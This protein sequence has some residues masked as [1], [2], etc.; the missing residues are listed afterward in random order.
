MRRPAARRAWISSLLL[1]PLAA[2]AAEGKRAANLFEDS[3]FEM[4]AG[5]WR[6]DKGKGTT[7]SFKVD[8]EAAFEG[9]RSML[10]TI[11]A[12]GDYG[13][14]FGQIV[15]GGQVGKTYTFA[16]FVRSEGGPTQVQL[17]IERPAKPWDRAVRSE[18]FT[19]AKDKWAELHVTFKVEKPFAE[20]WF[21]YVSCNRPNV[22]F[23]VD[24]F[25]LYEGD[26]V[27]FD[28]AAK[29][30]A[31]VSGVSLYEMLPTHSAPF[32]LRWSKKSGLRKIPEG[33]TP[34]PF[35]ALSSA[36][37]AN[38]RLA[39]EVHP[40]GAVQLYSVGEK[41]ALPRASLRP[42]P[43]RGASCTLSIAKNG[44]AASA[45]DV[46]YKD[47]AGKP[48][49]LRVELRMGQA[50]VETEPRGA[51][52]G[53]S[54][55]APCRFAILPDFFADDI[56][57]DAAELPVAK[58]ELPSE[59][60][61]IH[62]LPD[63]QALVMAV[64]DV[65]GDDVEVTLVGEGKER[66]IASS[67]IRFGSKGKIW[68]A[69][70]AAPGIWHQH[71]VAKDDAGKIV[72]LDWKP[73]FGAQWR[74]DW[75][76]EDGLSDSWEMIAQRSDGNF[77]KHWLGS[78]GTV[79]ANRKRWTT[80][81]GSFLYPCWID[82][83]GDAFLQPFA[84]SSRWLGPAVMYPLGRTG[85]TPLDTFTVLD[86]VR[87]TL[88]VGPCEYILDLEGQQ[89][90]YKGTATCANRDFLNPIY[91]RG[92]Q[93]KRRADINR[94]LDEVMLFIRH[95]RGRIE[96]YRDFGHEL[97]KYLAQHKQAH[98]ELAE[99]IAELETLTKAIDAYVDKRRGEIKT[100]DEAQAMVDDF[101]RTM[102]D[103][104][105]KDAF[106]RCKKFTSAIVVIGGSQDEL[107]GET[108]MA[109]KWVRQRAGLLM[110]LEPRIAPIAREIRART[111]K[112]LRS[113][114]G[115]EGARH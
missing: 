79:P 9:Q 100:P 40:T 58:A 53:L 42:V 36:V 93:K 19:I 77:V 37:L 66:H 27:P 96:T 80:V 25:R 85:A 41:G 59:N 32:Q 99:R 18:K 89:S 88:G 84:K 3:G 91:Q 68:V 34:Q 44:P 6:M 35:N 45:V 51:T 70:L 50:F 97:L 20:G 67:G 62:L 7:A 52:T 21:A 108:R 110:A 24:A 98:P 2:W 112:V 65:R 92:E 1:L 87:N 43:L 114:A 47:E 13:A 49:G 61:L 39:V 72:K 95:I 31:A 23:R 94:S 28:K 78:S 10:V 46:E 54:V 101:R 5:P 105:G 76:R 106:D 103:Y 104:E 115:H 4:G 69:A 57:V 14:Q 64:W 22:A 73:P 111:Q 60:F 75:Q 26:Y 11:E 109:V 56:A 81:F 48:A 16:V 15:A 33:E 12:V 38:D 83:Q 86:I 74:V 102:L 55:L 71:D 113:P 82:R 63:Q 107:A 90:H 17:E 29:A 30:E 8:A